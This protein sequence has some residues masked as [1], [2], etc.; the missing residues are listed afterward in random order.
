VHPPL[1]AYSHALKG[2]ND[3]VFISFSG[4]DDDEGLAW[5]TE[6][7][8]DMPSVTSIDFHDRKRLSDI[9]IKHNTPLFINV[10]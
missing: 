4:F 1:D 6:T 9:M 3:I 8:R 10:H 2:N 5:V 7:I